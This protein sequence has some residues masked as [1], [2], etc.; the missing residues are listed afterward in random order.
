[1]PFFIL[2]EPPPKSVR[3]SWEEYALALAR[4]A[5]I[6]SEDPYVKVGA[7]ALRYDKSVAAVGYNGPP[8]GVNI[9]WTNREERR[10]R[11]VHAEVN[12]LAHSRP[13]E[14]EILAT[15]LLPCSSCITVIAAY[16][17]KKVIYGEIYHRDDCALQL[18]EE[19]GIELI[20]RA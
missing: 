14:I 1:M 11:I 15:T 12:C 10:K 20:Q 13:G 5:S 8:R 4:T 16:G 18:A 19:F 2:P 3:P 7:C 9:D 6:R 17:I